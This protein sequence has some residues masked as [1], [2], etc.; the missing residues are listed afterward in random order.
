MYTTSSAPLDD[1][2][3][4]RGAAAGFSKF[5]KRAEPT[6]FIILA[7]ASRF[8]LSPQPRDTSSVYTSH[9]D[10]HELLSK[11]YSVFFALKTTVNFLPGSTQ[12]IRVKFAQPKHHTC[13]DKHTHDIYIR[14]DEYPYIHSGRVKTRAPTCPS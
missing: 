13:R 7:A 14:K 10:L 8:K 9:D 2:W 3:L 11:L 1:M 12:T 4:E 6:H 5:R